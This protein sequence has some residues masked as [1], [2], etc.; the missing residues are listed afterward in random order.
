MTLYSV[1]FLDK[2]VELGNKIEVLYNPTVKKVL[3][4]MACVTYKPETFTPS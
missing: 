2:R 1:L 4:T 3:T